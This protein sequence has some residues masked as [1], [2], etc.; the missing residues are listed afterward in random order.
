MNS[1]TNSAPKQNCKF[2]L[3]LQR[4]AK[5]LECT[6]CV[7]LHVKR[8]RLSSVSLYPCQPSLPKDQVELAYR[9][10]TRV[11]QHERSPMPMRRGGV[12]MVLR[13]HIRGRDRYIGTAG[14]RTRAQTRPT[15]AVARCQRAVVTAIRHWFSSS[16][17]AYVRQIC[18]GLITDV[19]FFS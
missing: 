5:N 4:T 17:V 14:A 13:L 8:P 12:A 16:V 10:S 18:A 15:L 3:E 19:V 2:S 1:L 7:Q 6:L 9:S 11:V